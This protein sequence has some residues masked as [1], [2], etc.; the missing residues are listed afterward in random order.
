MTVFIDLKINIFMRKYIDII[1]EAQDMDVL[2]E[3]PKSWLAAGAAAAIATASPV[4]AQT[5]NVTEP[6]TTTAS[7][8]TNATVQAPTSNRGIVELNG[9][10][11]EIARSI[12]GM[13]SGDLEMM[14][15]ERKELLSK[16]KLTDKPLPYKTAAEIP[17]AVELGYGD[18]K[19]LAVAFRNIL[20]KKGFF[21]D[22]LL[23]AQLHTENGSQHAVLIIRMGK[24]GKQINYVFDTRS[25]KIETVEDSIRAGYKYFAIESVPNGRF[26]GWNGKKFI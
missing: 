18:C 6:T 4:S 10:K 9:E 16:V 15:K 20:V 7:V 23:L 5:T 24:A 13:Q 21:K 8:N 19:S 26:L 17:D 14:E 25:G 12:T 2:E 11:V 1:T 22:S 3:G